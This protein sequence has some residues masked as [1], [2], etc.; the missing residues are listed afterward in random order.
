MQLKREIIHGIHKVIVSKSAFL[1]S[2]RNFAL[3]FNN[4]QLIAKLFE[5]KI[6]EEM[7]K[8]IIQKHS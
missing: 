8:K 4:V 5:K 1:R 6:D 7:K 2:F 3:T